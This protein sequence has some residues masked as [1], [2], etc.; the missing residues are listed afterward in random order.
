LTLNLTPKH[1]TKFDPRFVPLLIQQ[2][3]KEL[4]GTWF[5]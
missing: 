2:V 5:L 3:G 1:V 4:H